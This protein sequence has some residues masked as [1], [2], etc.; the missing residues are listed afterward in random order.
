MGSSTSA[1]VRAVFSSN[2]PGHLEPASVCLSVSRRQVVSSHS[3]QPLR[4]RGN[5]SFTRFQPK[6]NNKHNI[7]ALPLAL[8]LLRV[9]PQAKTVIDRGFIDRIWTKCGNNDEDDKISPAC[10]DDCTLAIEP[11]QLC[12]VN[13]FPPTR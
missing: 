13:A 1:I 3:N 2:E 8:L 12:G 10:C 6:R 4:Q 7:Q 11:S 9:L 5:L